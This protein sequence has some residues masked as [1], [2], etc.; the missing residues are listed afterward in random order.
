M[1]TELSLRGIDNTAFQR[2]IVRM[3]GITKRRI[4]VLCAEARD[5]A[6]A[7]DGML[8][9]WGVELFAGDHTHEIVERIEHEYRM[10]TS[11]L[12]IAESALR[13]VERISEV[14]GS[15]HLS[16][17]SAGIANG[18]DAFRYVLQVFAYRWITYERS[19]S[20]NPDITTL[21]TLPP[22]RKSAFSDYFNQELNDAKELSSTKAKLEWDSTQITLAAL[23]FT[24]KERGWLGDYKPY[25]AIQLAFTKSETIDQ[26]LRPSNLE[27]LMGETYF[28]KALAAFKGVKVN[29]KKK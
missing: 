18:R 27:E 19:V 20:Y 23:L 24:L 17:A 21:A 5:V 28:N 11:A 16:Q 13:E 12:N 2:M 25:R 14:V 22:A 29:P 7:E 10:G 15:K 8:E 9:W 1:P 3:A 6:Y 4:A 26:I